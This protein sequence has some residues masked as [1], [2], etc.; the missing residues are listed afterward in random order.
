MNEYVRILVMILVSGPSLSEKVKILTGIYI[1]EHDSDI[2]L[3]IISVI[4]SYKSDL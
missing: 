2:G 4:I 3:S 1:L